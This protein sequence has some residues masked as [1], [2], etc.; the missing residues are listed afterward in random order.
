MAEIRSERYKRGG[1]NE[2]E[3]SPPFTSIVLIFAC[4]I[5]KRFLSDLSFPYFSFF[6][7]SFL[8]VYGDIIY[9]R[10]NELKRK[11]REKGK[12]PSRKQYTRRKRERKF[13]SI[14]GNSLPL[15]ISTPSPPFLPVDPSPR[16]PRLMVL[17]ALK[18]L[19]GTAFT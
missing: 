19:H 17:E 11:Y 9:P 7:F 2:L 18:T 14:G 6:F 16:T 10:R 12:P 13:L 8:L 1:N 5:P 4:N 3:V 15:P